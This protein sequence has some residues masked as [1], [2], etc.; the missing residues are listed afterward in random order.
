MGAQ[1]DHHS[2]VGAA[3][4][5]RKT[6]VLRGALDTV[7]IC[8][9]VMSALMDKPEILADLVNAVHGTD[10]GPGFVGELGEAVLALELEFNAAAGISIAD[11]RLPEFMRTEA[12]PPQDL[13]FDVPQAELDGLLRTDRVPEMQSTG[14]KP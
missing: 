6:Q 2:P 1:V 4:L 9:F 10:Y 8:A 12:L 14:G 11:D 5:S 3:Q 13:V 7:N